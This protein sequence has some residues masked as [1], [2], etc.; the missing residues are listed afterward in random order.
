MVR[1]P[2]VVEQ[3]KPRHRAQPLS[4]MNK[5]TEHS[6]DTCQLSLPTQRNEALTMRHISPGPPT[7]PAGRARANTWSFGKVRETASLVSFLHRSSSA[8][9]GGTHCIVLLR[10]AQCFTALHHLGNLFCIA[11]AGRRSIF[12]GGFQGERCLITSAKPLGICAPFFSEFYPRVVM[13]IG[14]A[15]RESTQR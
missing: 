3:G 2:C 12:K 10:A 5:R 7:P 11:K 15:T 8:L 13:G 14:V 9:A 4:L 1:R 6:A